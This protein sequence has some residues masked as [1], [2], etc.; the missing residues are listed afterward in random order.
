MKPYDLFGTKTIFIKYIFDN[1][2][3]LWQVCYCSFHAGKIS[4]LFFYRHFK[5]VADP[6]YILLSKKQTKGYLS[7]TQLSNIYLIVSKFT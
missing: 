2:D 6:D 3:I 5:I 1:K 4:I 7:F